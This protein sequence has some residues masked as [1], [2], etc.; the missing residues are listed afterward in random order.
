[1]LAE[2]TASLS[3]AYNTVSDACTAGVYIWVNSKT[4]KLYV[5]LYGSRKPHPQ[6][7]PG[8]QEMYQPTQEAPQLLFHP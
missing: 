2:L 1:M 4:S 3:Q 8:V 6:A 5:G 7:V